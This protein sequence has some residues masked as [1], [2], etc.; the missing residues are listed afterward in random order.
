MAEFVYR[1]DRAG[2]ASLSSQLADNLR[3]AIRNHIFRPGD[4]LPGIRRL[5]ELCGTSVR[6]PIQALAELESQ[7]LIKSRARIG[8][9]VLDS[10]RK[11]WRGR[12]MLIKPGICVN[13]S[14][15]VLYD[16]IAERLMRSDWKCYE[17][18]MP[19][20]E[21]SGYDLTALRSEL[22]ARYD[23]IVVPAF[24]AKAVCLI[25]ASGTPYFAIGASRGDMGDNCIGGTVSSELGVMQSLAARCRDANIKHI[26]QIGFDEGLFNVWASLLDRAVRLETAI[27]HPEISSRR[28]ESF[29]RLGY[30]TVN[31]RLADRTKGLPDLVFFADDFLAIG[32]LQAIAEHGLKAPEDLRIVTLANAG[33]V[34]PYA[35]PLTRLECDM[36][37]DGRAIAR[38]I[39]KFFSHGHK[40]GSLVRSVRFV[41]GE[42]F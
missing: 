27:V 33:F 32:G 14:L 40:S 4:V 28:L 23:L 15:S 10:R 22:H 7:G 11:I 17:V 21:R 8:S 5:A 29:M 13:Y 6:V 2:S 9:V 16:T 3:R 39:L 34:L 19:R 12:V 24:D 36:G 38:A 41:P 30:E 37:N 18:L 42:T 35:R 26:Y 25:E 1:L 20:N 31:R